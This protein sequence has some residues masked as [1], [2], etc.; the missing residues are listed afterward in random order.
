MERL[1]D[2]QRAQMVLRKELTTYLDEWFKH[3]D[4]KVHI[5]PFFDKLIITHNDRVQV[6]RIADIKQ[7]L[8][9]KETKNTAMA[10]LNQMT[11]NMQKQHVQTFHNILDMFEDAGIERVQLKIGFE[12]LV[13]FNVDKPK[14][15]EKIKEP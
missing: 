14:R 7:Q 9:V 10:L 4:K 3:R 12:I 2:A 13:T 6:D 8:S 5:Y 1:S 15:W 11:I